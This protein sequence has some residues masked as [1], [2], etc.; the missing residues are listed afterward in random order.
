MKQFA[1]V[2]LPLPFNE[3]FDYLIPEDKHYTVGEIVSVPFGRKQIYGVI[4]HIGDKPDIDEKK[5][6][7]I[8]FSAAEK[9]FATPPLSAQLINMIE[10]QADYYVSEKGKVLG[11]V[12]SNKYFKEVKSRTEKELN[13]KEIKLVIPELSEE[14]KKAADNMAVRTDNFNVTMLEGITGSGKT[15]VYFQV[16][17]KILAEGK[18]VLLMLPEIML[19]SQ[20]IKRF[21]RRFGFKPVLWH[22]VVSEAKRRKSF[23]SIANGEAKVVIGARSALHLPY[24]NLGLIIVDEEHDDSYKQDEQVLYNARDM[25]V[26]R[27]KFENIMVILSSA[28]PSLE[29]YHNIKNGKY[30][31]EVLKRRFNEV[32]L[33]QVGLIDMREDDL[34]AKEFISHRLRAEIEANLNEKQ[35]TLLF[36][37][38]RGYAPLT[39]CSKCGFRFRSPDTSAWMVM[40][41]DSHGIPYLECHHTGFTMPMPKQ[42]PSCK[43]ENSFRPCG[44]GIQRLAE[45]IKT[46]F[47]QARVAELASDNA[48][49]QK[50]VEEIISQ[51][52]NGEIDIVI[53]TQVIAKGHH[54]P[55]LSLVGVVDGDLGLDFENLRT[56]EKTFQLLHQVSGRAGR[57]KHKGRVF[58]QTYQPENKVMQTLAANDLQSF[59]EYEL[60]ERKLAGMPPFARLCA[61]TVSAPDDNSA[62]RSAKELVSYFERNN[63]VKIFG[64][65]QALYHEYRGTFRHRLLLKAARNFNMQDYIRRALTKFNPS[66]NI[67]IKIDIDPYNFS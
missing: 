19:T 12:Y 37:N 22:S 63:N 36:L 61:I 40:H 15:E 26:I 41:I 59:L 9:G 38:R 2:L 42:C 30:S 7:P 60:E 20:M 43:A 65:A 39:L 57:E 35:Q 27:A 31:H 53:G 66:R 56:T 50:K 58:I 24:K 51:I 55:A 33:P 54:F 28:T 49:S 21:E 11:L 44:P 34:T 47:P 32:T 45:E 8:T 17:E 13:K 23:F 64:P 18:Q 16:M 4:W 67:K 52:E 3:A 10:W 46:L 48:T 6:K 14:Q 29:S 25:A 1:K 5:I 62:H